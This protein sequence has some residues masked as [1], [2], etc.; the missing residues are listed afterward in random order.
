MFKYWLLI[1][2]AFFV[3]GCGYRPVIESDESADASAVESKPEQPVQVQMSDSAFLAAAHKGLV[4]KV[5]QG[6]D[7]G[8]DIHASDPSDGMTALHLA[9]HDGRNKVV[10]LLLANKALVDIRDGQGHTPLLMAAYNGHTD[11][12]R[13]LYKKGAEI[14]ARDGQGKTP[15]IHAASGP[16]AETVEFLLDS[17]ADI[18]AVDDGEG[19]TSLMTAAALGEKDVVQLLLKRG[20]DKSIADDDGD[21]ALSHAK[22]TGH[23]EIAGLLE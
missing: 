12:V 7:G 1:S 6:I 18:N 15:L 17:G 8:I 13:M 11:V 22:S 19:F 4:D 23:S 14:D 20:A 5:Q 9:A 21:T 16:Y 10:E 2:F 3:V